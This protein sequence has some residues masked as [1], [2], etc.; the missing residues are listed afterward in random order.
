MLVYIGYH[1]K[2]LMKCVARGPYVRRA[3]NRLNH[4]CFLRGDDNEKLGIC[5][6]Q[7]RLN[8]FKVIDSFL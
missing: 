2:D 3:N 5:G 4:V 6:A 8:A 7:K 1:F